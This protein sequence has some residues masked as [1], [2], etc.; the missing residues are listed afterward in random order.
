ME[1]K[2]R[3]PEFPGK[4]TFAMTRWFNKMYL[5]GLLFHPDEPAE[6]IV[7]IDSGKATFTPAECVAL[8]MAVAFMF[9]KHGDKVYE[10]GVRY[11]HKAIGFTPEYSET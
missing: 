6:D 2:S 4:S 10:V 11:F 3:I 1:T 8:N 5:A 9:E 7:D